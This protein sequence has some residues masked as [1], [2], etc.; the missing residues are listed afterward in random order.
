MFAFIH[1][2]VDPELFTIG[3]LTVRWYGL[4]FALGF[5]LGQQLLIRMFKAEGKPESDVEVLT[6]YMVL[7]T[8][9]GARLGHMLFYDFDDLKADPMVFLFL[10]LCTCIRATALPFF[11]KA[12][13]CTSGS[14]CDPGSRTYG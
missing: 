10:S 2:N 11:T 8:V 3:S 14:A 5:L 7:A 1:W 9:I 4:L 12:N 13:F 6:V